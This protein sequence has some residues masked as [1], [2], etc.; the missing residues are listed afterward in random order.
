MNVLNGPGQSYS[1]MLRFATRRNTASQ[2]VQA[3]QSETVVD[4]EALQ[5]SNQQLRNNARETGVDLY[6]L[7]LQKKSL[8]TYARTTEQYSESNNAST[9]ENQDSVYSYD[10]AEVNQSLEMVQKRATG[11]FLYEQLS[12]ASGQN[13]PHSSVNQFV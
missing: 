2:V 7:N 9:Q 4:L 13:N 1:D 12:N 10:A 6:A 8:E 3:K 11:V 5:Q